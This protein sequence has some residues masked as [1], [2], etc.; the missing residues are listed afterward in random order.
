MWWSF[1]S[2]LQMEGEGE[3]REKEGGEEEEGGEGGRRREERRREGREERKGVETH[4]GRQKE[5]TKTHFR[6][7][8]RTTVMRRQMMEM[9]SP[10]L[11]TICS[12]RFGGC[13][14]DNQSVSHSTSDTMWWRHTHRA[15]RDYTKLTAGRH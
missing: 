10:T 2:T 11:E 6:V 1:P 9:Q 4:L 12:G 14:E 7:K 8:R 15:A 3:G 13:L 5:D